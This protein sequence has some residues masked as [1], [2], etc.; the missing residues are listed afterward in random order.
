[1]HTLHWIM[2]I[3]GHTLKTEMHMNERLTR[4]RPQQGLWVS[5]Y[6]AKKAYRIIG[7]PPNR[8][9]S[10]CGPQ[11]WLLKCAAITFP[12]VAAVLVPWDLSSCSNETSINFDL[13]ELLPHLHGIDGHGMNQIRVFVR[14]ECSSPSWW[15][16]T[17][18][19]SFL[20]ANPSGVQDDDKT[21]PFFGLLGLRSENHQRSVPCTS[22]PM[23]ELLFTRCNKKKLKSARKPHYSWNHISLFWTGLVPLSK[24]HWNND[25][26]SGVQ[27][28]GV[29]ATDTIHR[30]IRWLG[31]GT[32][33]F[34]EV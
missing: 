11:I 17:P 29:C 18:P 23:Y 34:S 15:E 7:G 14:C 5:Y 19:P 32:I 30:L 31:T 8:H 12:S 1:M 21:A 13:F 6:F 22:K 16:Y 25:S 27:S 28:T 9:S 24:V 3:S 33:S 10:H 4:S 20:V 26:V 2:N